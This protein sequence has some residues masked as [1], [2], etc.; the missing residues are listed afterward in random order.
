MNV[1]SNENSNLSELNSSKHIISA[2]SPTLAESR[3]I[4]D[5]C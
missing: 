2:T 1:N 5:D 4:S 3:N